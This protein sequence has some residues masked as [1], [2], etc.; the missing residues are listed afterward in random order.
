[1]PPA[2][3]HLEEQARRRAEE[4]REQ[5]AKRVQRKDY[6]AGQMSAEEKVGG[7]AEAGCSGLQWCQ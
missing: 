2:C 3:R 7:A 4:E 6:K 5:A 1:V